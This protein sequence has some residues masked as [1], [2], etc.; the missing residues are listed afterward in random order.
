MKQ[1]WCLI[2][3]I[4][5]AC[6]F[7]GC[8]A[9]PKFTPLA[10]PAPGKALI[11]IYRKSGIVGA[12]GYDKLYVNNDYIGALHS[13]GYTYCE[14]PQG[15]AVFYVNPKMVY[16]PGLVLAAALANVNKSQYEKLRLQVD[17]GKTY[18][19]NL[20]IDSPVSHGMRLVDNSVGEKE[21]RGL[22]LCSPGT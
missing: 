15:L 21:I 1:Y 14:V 20:Y 22:S 10:A 11:Y 5:F 9:G 8:V 2:I 4:V 6:L 17:A 12:A 18:F 13:G 16:A 7:T 3:G 19:V